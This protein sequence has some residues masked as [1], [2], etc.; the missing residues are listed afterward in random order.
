MRF[1]D[2]P[3]WAKDLSTLIQSRSGLQ[4]SVEC[5]ESQAPDQHSEKDGPKEVRE[6]ASLFPGRILEREPLFDQM[7][8]N[9]YQPG[10]VCYPIISGC[11]LAKIHG[12]LK[13]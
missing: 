8:V 7:I 6:S 11:S 4:S 13:C 2:L 1:G 10:E 9:L 12:M 3:L 5:L